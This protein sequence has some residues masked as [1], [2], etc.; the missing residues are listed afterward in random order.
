[1]VSRATL[2]N[3]DEIKRLDIRIGDTVIVE[4]AGD[5]I[6]D[7]VQVLPKLRT[8]KEKFGKCLKV[9]Q[10]VIRKPKEKKISLR[11]IAVIKLPKCTARRF[12]SF[13]IAYGF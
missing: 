8:G 12:V 7:V 11:G 1:M 10:F 9:A 4:K 13:C 3:E 6:P 2:H 5:I